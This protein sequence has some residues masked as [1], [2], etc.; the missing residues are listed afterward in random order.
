VKGSDRGSWRRIKLMPFDAQVS[1]DKRVKDLARRVFIAHELPGIL[2]WLL[3]GLKRWI[4][5][6]KLPEC[7]RIQDAIS[8]YRD[9][10]DVIAQFFDAEGFEPTYDESDFVPTEMLQLSFASYLER[11]GQQKWSAKAL[12]EALRE[13][14]LKSGKKGHNRDRVWLGLRATGINGA[15]ICGEVTR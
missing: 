13:H 2:N 3:R 15:Y 6:G 7:K 11:T 8:E 10:E 14:R 9:E 1:P 12:G 4:E 5:L